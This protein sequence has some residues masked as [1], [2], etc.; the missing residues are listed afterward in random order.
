MKYEEVQGSGVVG[1]ALATIGIGGCIL[2]AALPAIYLK[3]KAKY[4]VEKLLGRLMHK[5][6]V[7]LHAVAS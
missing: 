1:I 4:T 5:G 7:T 6:P 3:A 2:E